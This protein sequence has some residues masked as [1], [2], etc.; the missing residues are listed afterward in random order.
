METE[1][2]LSLWFR[3]EQRYRAAGNQSV[4]NSSKKRGGRAPLSNS[5]TVLHPQ[6][7]STHMLAATPVVCAHCQLVPHATRK[8]TTGELRC[9]RCVLHDQRSKYLPPHITPAEAQLEEL[10]IGAFIS[11]TKEL[12]QPFA[13]A[14]SSAFHHVTAQTGLSQKEINAMLAPLAASLALHRQGTVLS[15]P[16]PE[17]VVNQEQ[18]VALMSHVVQQHIAQKMSAVQSAH[19]VHDTLLHC[20]YPSQAHPYAAYAFAP[21][22]AEEEGPAVHMEPIRFAETEGLTQVASALDGVSADDI[23]LRLGPLTISGPTLS[24]I[25]EVAGM[26]TNLMIAKLKT[27]QELHVAVKQFCKD[28]GTEFATN[29]FIRQNSEMAEEA[30]RSFFGG[31]FTDVHALKKYKVGSKELQKVESAATAKEVGAGP[32]ALK[33]LDFVLELVKKQKVMPTKKSLMASGELR[34]KGMALFDKMMN[35]MS[36]SPYYAGNALQHV[37]TMLALLGFYVLRNLKNGYGNASNFFAVYKS[38]AANNAIKTPAP[39]PETEA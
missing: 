19:L 21:Y 34:K 25:K 12:T 24:R 6:P 32:V 8:K 11:P 28:V 22:N 13:L 31:L 38:W 33:L 20:G 17:R 1:A 29:A 27:G 14:R 39:W 3:S 35:I 4:G 7:F 23:G 36:R 37:S 15:P 10:A 26:L 30:M 16:M 5:N 2:C 9:K 18:Y